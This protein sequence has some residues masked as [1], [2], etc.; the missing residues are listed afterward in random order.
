MKNIL[1][2]SNPNVYAHYVGAAEL[3]PLVSTIHYDEVSPFRSS[4]NSYGVSSSKRV[5]Q[6]TSRMA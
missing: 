3:H 4:L 5:S 1:H 2:V 6:R